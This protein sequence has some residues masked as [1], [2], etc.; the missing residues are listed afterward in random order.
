MLTPSQFAYQTVRRLQEAGFEALLAGGCV[1]DQLLGKEPKDFDVATSAPPEK[2][3]EVFGHQRTRAI[4]AAFG[5]VS[6]SG[7]RSAGIIEIATFRSDGVYS[8][9]RHPDQV[10]FANAELDAQRRD[11]TI[12][13]IFLD[14]VRDKVVDFVN[15]QQDLKERIVRAIGDP[16]ARFTEDKLRMLRAVRF[17]ADLDFT[18]DRSTADVIRQLAHTI[19]IVSAERIGAELAMMLVRPSRSRAVELLAD[20]RLLCQPAI[21]P[22][23]SALVAAADAFHK[24]LQLLAWLEDPSLAVSLVALCPDDMEP[25]ALVPICGRLKF[26]NEVRDEAVWLRR[27]CRTLSVGRSCSWSQIQ[28]LVAVQHAAKALVLLRARALAGELDRASVEW[29]ESTLNLSPEQLNPIPLIT[30]GDLMSMGLA[31]GPLFSTILHEVR[32]RQLDSI[33]P[34]RQTALEFAKQK[35]AEWSSGQEGT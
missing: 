10:T 31:P 26:S 9:G 15:G 29:L 13:G 23:L 24:K 2:V 6:L 18:L 32:M 35:A 14:P 5:V 11:F 21:L 1:R 16:K 8:D 33:I 17:A 20:T 12:N 4:G 19:G 28:P 22:E 25:A 27:H 30:G 3:R 34:D 7:P